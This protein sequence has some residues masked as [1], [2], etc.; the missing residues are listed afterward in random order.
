[1][2]FEVVQTD[3]NV[4]NGT[5]MMKEVAGHIGNVENPRINLT[6]Y[7]PSKAAGPAPM[8][9]IVG[10]G[11]FGFGG[12]RG[13]VRGTNQVAGAGTT[14]AP[15]GFGASGRGGGPGGFGF[16]FGGAP[17]ADILARGWGIASAGEGM[18]QLT[19]DDF[20]S[21]RCRF[22][23]LK[24]GRGHRWKYRPHRRDEPVTICDL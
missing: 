3:L 24:T 5:A 21:L 9:V 12:P 7:L 17:V 13:G 10:P 6:M 22:D 19:P 11:S 15:S 8:V 18:N 16:R 23:T 1:V 4:L 20:E 14:N 2:K